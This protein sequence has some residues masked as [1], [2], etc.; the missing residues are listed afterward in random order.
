MR[1]Y[2][3]LMDETAA[4]YEALRRAGVQIEF[5]P[6]GADPYARSPA[7]GYIDMRDN[8]R[9]FVFP[10]LEGFGSG[11][12]LSREA[13]ANNPLLR[14]SGFQISGRPAT[15]N[16][17]FRAVHDV[18][19][20]NGPGNPFFRHQGE[21][22]AFRHHSRMYSPTAGRAAGTELTGQNNWLNFGPFGERN[23][24]ASAADTI[25]ADQKINVLPDWVF[26][27]L[28]FLGQ[29]PRRRR[30]RGGRVARQD[31]GAN[32]LSQYMP[33][34]M[35]TPLPTNQ[36]PTSS[37]VQSLMRQLSGTLPQQPHDDGTMGGG[38][39]PDSGIDG[40]W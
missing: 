19:G 20:H 9:L 23:R 31:G 27:E 25:Y 28:S 40:T 33:S 4:Q 39:G 26:E 35:V 11:A 22:R 2:E 7:L 12:G 14:D 1:N 13:I 32:P 17:L 18:F 37:A 15:Y 21:E 30:R 10:T 16:D 3:A 34:W 8:N 38:G 5:N 36:K 24:T 29:N 6:P